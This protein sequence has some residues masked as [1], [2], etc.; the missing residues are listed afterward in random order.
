LCGDE[1]EICEALEGWVDPAIHGH[2]SRAYLIGV[3]LR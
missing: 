1:A 3:G 2:V